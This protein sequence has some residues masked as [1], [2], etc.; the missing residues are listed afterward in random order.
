MLRAGVGCPADHLCLQRR[1]WW[2]TAPSGTRTTTVPTVTPWRGTAP[3]GPTAP[4]WCR[5]GRVSRRAGRVGL[6][7]LSDPHRGEAL[8]PSSSSL[9]P[10]MPPGHLLVAHPPAHLPPPVPGPA[11]AALLEV[12][13]LLQ[14]GGSPGPHPTGVPLG[15]R[16]QGNPHVPPS[17]GAVPTP[18][19]RLCQ[20][21]VAGFLG[22][23]GPGVSRMQRV[24]RTNK[25]ERLCPPGAGHLPGKKDRRQE[26]AEH[27]LAWDTEGGRGAPT[28]A[29]RV[30]FM[31][32]TGRK[33][34]VIKHF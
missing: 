25:K 2:S 34:S 17:S 24:T 13:C 23:P 9:L 5:G 26:S 18:A 27:G 31:R 32:V 30:V 19:P 4:S 14:G 12:L 10:R 29:P 7:G 22:V 15:G 8:A 21:P 33:R 16:G 3:P 28:A 1:R 11:A 6:G 20:P